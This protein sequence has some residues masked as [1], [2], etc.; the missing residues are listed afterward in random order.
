MAGHVDNNEAAADGRR[1][2]L[3]GGFAPSLITFR[4]PLIA[5]MVA[6]GHRVF[7]LAPGIDQA[8]AAAVRALGAE[9][10]DIRLGRASLNPLTALRTMADLRRLF[11]RLKPDVVI[12]YTI[13]PILLGGPAAAA[14]GARFVALVTGLG[15]AFTGGREPKRLLS[16]F[17]GRLGYRR[18]LRKAAV[19]IF[20]NGDDREDFRKMGLLPARLPTAVVNGSGVDIAHFAPRPL[21]GAPSFLMIARFLKD[22]GVREYTQAARR[23]KRERPDLRIALAGWRDASPDAIGEAE[24]HEIEAA[25][26][27]MLGRLD[28]VR[29]AIGEASVYV[30]PSYREGTPRSVLEAMAMGRAVVTTDAPGCRETVREGVNGFLV[31]PRDADALLAAMRRFVE[32]PELAARMGAASRRIAEEKYDVHQVNREILRHAGL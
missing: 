32:E 28:D 23:L 17:I 26:V 5:E 30:L 21:P 1:V 13:T 18:G 7:A 16:R 19:A 12:A 24:L 11:R 29:P 20:Q 27:E 9:P 8:V 14:V 2:V 6:R 31:P 3:L 22:K 25:G 4:G 15:Y 10:I